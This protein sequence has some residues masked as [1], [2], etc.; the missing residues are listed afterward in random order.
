[1]V[2]FKSVFRAQAPLS[3][4]LGS[5]KVSARL[6]REEQGRRPPPSVLAQE[7]RLKVG[8]PARPGAKVTRDELDLADDYMVHLDLGGEGVS[9]ILKPHGGGT[10]LTGFPNAINVNAAL[11]N[12]TRVSRTSPNLERIPALIEL[13]NWATNPTLPLGDHFADY[14]TMQN[15]PLTATN[16]AEIARVIRPG[17]T[18]ELWVDHDLYHE[19]VQQLAWRLGSRVE[20]PPELARYQANG[21]FWPTRR[22][23]I[24]PTEW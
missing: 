22:R 19:A 15:A 7:V 5:Q 13:Q 24:V 12:G 23:I 6:L 2:A 16:I 3:S 17:G 21:P 9:K 18:V 4:R 10:W 1:M 8:Q 20:Y 14:I 11:Y